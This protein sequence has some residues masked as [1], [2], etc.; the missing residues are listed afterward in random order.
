MQSLSE[1]ERRELDET[2]SDPKKSEEWA[3]KVIDAWI[4]R[5]QAM[6]EKKRTGKKS[7]KSSKTSKVR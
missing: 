7:R 3:N 1:E 4:A 6:K 5:R 2:L